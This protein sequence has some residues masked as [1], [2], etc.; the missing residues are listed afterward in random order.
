MCATAVSNSKP[1]PFEATSD[2]RSPATDLAD[3]LPLDL[4]LM[5][6]WTERQARA[7]FE[8][9]GSVIPVLPSACVSLAS[10]LDEAALASFEALLSRDSME[11]WCMRF[12]H[13]ARACMLHRLRRLGVHAL[14]DRQAICNAFQRAWREGRLAGPT[15]QLTPLDTPAQLLEQAA[16]HV[17]HLRSLPAEEQRLKLGELHLQ[18]DAAL[19]NSSRS[20]VEVIRDLNGVRLGDAM[21]ELGMS[22]DAVQLLLSSRGMAASVP[23]RKVAFW[24]N[25]MGERG[26]EV[27]IFDYADFGERLLG[28]S[29]YVLYPFPPRYTAM[30]HRFARRFGKRCIGV[31]NFEQ[32]L[33]LCQANGISLLYILKEGGPH[34]PTLPKKCP[35]A[36]AVHAIFDAR[37]P[38]G[39]AYARIS[40]TVPDNGR[41]CPVV[42]HIVRPRNSI[43]GDLR[44]VLRIPSNATVFGR[45]GGL[46]TFS[47]D[48]V[49]SVVIEVA[50]AK[51]TTIYFLFMNTLQFCDPLPNVI[52]LEATSDEEE[53]SRFIRTCDAMLHARYSGETFGLAPGIT[54]MFW[55]TKL[56]SIMIEH[57]SCTSFMHLIGKML[58]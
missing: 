43:G 18:E 14:A 2:R 27:A 50:V 16:A 57:L 29:S 53:K 47:I 1:Q 46:D 20:S 23:E 41:G 21:E 9:G 36:T 37:V 30:A 31:E 17:S 10:L 56:S 11:T 38:S 4:P 34:V 44:R 40:P 35:V 28:L 39:D 15:P 26:T 45:Y 42:P 12:H 3:D 24:T 54:L 6:R 48:F 8:S 25:Q 51:P 52:H 33:D 32:A 19:I 55:A 58:A 13:A 5:T 22:F 7:F 49:H